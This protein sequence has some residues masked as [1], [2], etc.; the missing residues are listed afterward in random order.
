MTLPSERAITT[1]PIK[2]QGIQIWTINDGSCI[3]CFFRSAEDRFPATYQQY[4]RLLIH[5]E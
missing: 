2:I 1:N 3:C 5:L 4:K